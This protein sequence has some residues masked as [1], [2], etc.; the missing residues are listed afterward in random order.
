M[1]SKFILAF[2][3]HSIIGE[4]HGWNDILRPIFDAVTV[5]V[6]QLRG[7]KGDLEGDR[8][9]LNRGEITVVARYQIASETALY[10]CFFTHLLIL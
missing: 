9:K 8:F 7:R 4:Y 2:V 3:R 10:S 5:V 1:Q 6:Y